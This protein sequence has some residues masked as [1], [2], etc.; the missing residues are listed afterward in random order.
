MSEIS[1]RLL[2]RSIIEF[3]KVGLLISD[4]EFEISLACI[5]A[6]RIKVLSFIKAYVHFG[7]KKKK[8]PVGS[9]ASEDRENDISL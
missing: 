9:L 7:K 6:N 4:W 5:I 8:K 1:S 3:P 2:K